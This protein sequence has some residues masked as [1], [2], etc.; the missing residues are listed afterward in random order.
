MQ[1]NL[2]FD[3]EM[4][5][6]LNDLKEKLNVKNDSE[7]IARALDCLSDAETFIK[8]EKYDELQRQYQHLLVKLGELQGE[9]NVYKQ[10]S[11]PPTPGRRWWQFWK[12]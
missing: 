11:I 4:I 10:L 1:K 2:R 7:L 3:D 12:K 6:K 9:L 5:K 8:I